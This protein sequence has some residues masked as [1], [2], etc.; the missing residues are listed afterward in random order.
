MIAD[1]I[2]GVKYFLSGFEAIQQP[3]IRRYAVMPILVNIILFSLG[4]YV[5]GDQFSSL[6]ESY[7]P[8]SEGYWVILVYILW[9]VFGL[10]ILIMLFFSFTLLANLIGSP[11]NGPLAAAVERQ[12][13]EHIDQGSNSSIIGEVAKAIGNE[14]RKWL[15]YLFWAI[16]LL[17][18]SFIPVINFASPFLWFIFG[19][20]ILAIEYLDYPMGNHNY[21]FTAIKSTLRQQRMLALGFGTAVMC[22]TLIPIINLVVM[23]AA[24]AGASKLWVREIKTSQ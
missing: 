17:I 8:D 19:A 16:P 21:S 5:L 18:I 6:M 11:F 24:V 13:D 12:L 23:P 20:W 9:V 10:L 15:Y 1:F 2:R 3:G 7:L 4:I 14:L 22:F